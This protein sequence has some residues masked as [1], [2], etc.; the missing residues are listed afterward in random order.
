MKNTIL[1][2]LVAIMAMPMCLAQQN[3]ENNSV[4]KKERFKPRFTIAADVAWEID[5][6]AERTCLPDI[7]SSCSNPLLSS[8]KYGVSFDVQLSRHSGIETGIYVRNKLNTLTIPLLY[9]YYSGVL[10]FAVGASVD[11]D[12]TNRNHSSSSGYYGLVLKLSKDI[13]IYRGL[14]AEPYI[15]LNPVFELGK[16]GAGLSRIWPGVGVGLKYRF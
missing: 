9:K 16:Y 11:I 3:G 1:A 12:L 14:S 2:I 4:E 15:N 8:M 10:N 7:N 5:L 6:D 13:K